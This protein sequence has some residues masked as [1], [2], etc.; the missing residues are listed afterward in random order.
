MLCSGITS[1]RFKSNGPASQI[2]GWEAY[3]D[4]VE[5][6]YK[7]PTIRYIGLV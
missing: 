3:H 5:R 4:P 1:G 7:Q 6:L 2:M